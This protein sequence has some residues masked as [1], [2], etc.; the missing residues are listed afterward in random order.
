MQRIV[1][2]PHHR[3]VIKSFP[4]KLNVEED[5]TSESDGSTSQDTNE[6]KNSSLLRLAQLSLEDYKWRS[7]VF[8]TE[9]ADRRVEESLAR[10]MGD[11]A[12]YVRPMDASEGKIGPLVSIFSPSWQLLFLAIP[13]DSYSHLLH[14]VFL[15]NLVWVG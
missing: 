4:L 8:K 14:R 1:S 7:S 12:A 10:M 2:L 11:E 6:V 9:E 13:V 3:D 15:K 5:S